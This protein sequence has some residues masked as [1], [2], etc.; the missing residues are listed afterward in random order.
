[1][2]FSFFVSIPWH[3][4]GLMLVHFGVV[5]FIADCYDSVGTAIYITEHESLLDKGLGILS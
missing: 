5:F 1:M 4:L 2:I 3:S